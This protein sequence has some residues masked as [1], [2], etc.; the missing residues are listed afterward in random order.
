ML[1]EAAELEHNL[2]CTYLYA[3]FSLKDD[4][5]GLHALEAQAVGRWRREVIAVAVDEMSHLVAVWNITS[6]LGGVPRFGRGN[7]PLDPGYL[8]AGIVVKLAPFGEA[9]LQHFIHLERPAESSEPEG[10]G[11]AY[12]RHF[13][14]ATA[15]E[16]LTPTGLDYATVGEFYTA[17]SGGLRGLVA[18]AGEAAVFCGDRALQLTAAE[19]NL[20]GATSVLCLKTALASLEAIV[21]QGEGAPAHA[22]GSH[23]DRFCIIRAEYRALKASNPAFA[24]SH[25]A[26]TN[27]VLRKPPRPE[28]R[29]WIEAQDAIKVV[30][31]SN[32]AYGLML[33]LLA[34]AYAIPSPHPDKALTIDL[35]IG[36]MRAMTAL[37]EHAARLPAG[38]SNPDCHAGMSFTA[39]RDAAA[40]PAGAA[41][42]RYFVERFAELSAVANGLAEN[43]NA[44][45]LTGARLL[46][47]LTQRAARRLSTSSPSQALVQ[48]VENAPV[49]MKP[50]APAAIA[51]GSTVTS[52]A[53]VVEGQ[54][55][56]LKFD[57]PRC[58][59]ARFCVTGA[60]TV[61]L[62]NV[63]GP[64]LHPDTMQ[65]ER[66]VAIAHECPSGAISYVR[67]D[68][69]ANEAAPPVNLAAIREAGPYAFRGQLR[70]DGVDTGY[71]ATLCRCGASQNKPFCDGS[72]KTAGFNAS[73]EPDTVSA[74][75]LSSRD[76]LLAVEP[77]ADGPLQ[78]RGNLEITSGTGRV[79][80]RLTSAKLCRCGASAT[81]PFCDGTH[82]RIG[83]KS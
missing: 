66:L 11:F 21:L 79:V 74:D 34:T 43:G 29:V 33:R 45:L 30:D 82:A 69:M 71:R 39:L 62:A 20:P 44:R 40:L 65:V 78:V 55:L 80:A 13:T 42:N 58:I 72:H 63:V 7:F 83:F 19:V 52:G 68:G 16:R 23:F 76:G 41:A 57:T 26:A 77:Q 4:Q 22:E 18:Q 36:L 59:H 15:G 12:E 73:G 24:P 17:I 6:A 60:P 46:A 48:R 10:D 75:M 3:A 27:P 9:V 1:Y 8:P 25:P 54:S 50:A 32:A 37:G 51:A 35:G 28:G 14:R 53:E 31:I 64:W 5:E 67:K 2:M 47:A 81:K 61:F 70:I 38:P 49:A 56:T